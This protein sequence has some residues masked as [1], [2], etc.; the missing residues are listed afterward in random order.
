MEEKVFDFITIAKIDLS[1]W[2][3]IHVY[4]IEIQ[5]M[6]KYGFFDFSIFSLVFR[7][8]LVEWH[9]FEGGKYSQIARFAMLT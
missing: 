1:N 8:C 5:M 4:F 2:Y 6:E 7:C 9:E 3:C